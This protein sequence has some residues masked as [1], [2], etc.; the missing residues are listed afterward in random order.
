[1]ITDTPEL[2][3]LLGQHL[4]PADLR[5]CIQVSRLWHETLISCLWRELNDTEWPWRQM[6]AEAQALSND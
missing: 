3:L 6:F 5:R 2:V 1:M 4:N